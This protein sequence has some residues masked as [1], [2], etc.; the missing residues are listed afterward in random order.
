MAYPQVQQEG[1]IIRLRAN[2]QDFA[3]HGG[4]T[5]AP[6]LCENPR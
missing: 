5:R 2:G 4:G 3:Y 6:F 1:V